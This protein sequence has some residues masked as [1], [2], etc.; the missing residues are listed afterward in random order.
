MVPFPIN[1]R[2]NDA[3][4]MSLICAALVH[5][6]LL[7]PEASAEHNMPPGTS[8]DT[9]TVVIPADKPGQAFTPERRHRR[10]RKP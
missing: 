6:L 4:L 2:D 10:C 9:P 7:R 8:V 3:F 1:K 5:F